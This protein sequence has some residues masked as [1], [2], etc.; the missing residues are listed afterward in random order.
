MTS[1][2]F[3]QTNA[4][5]CLGRDG[6]KG[7]HAHP[8]LSRLLIFFP[9]PSRRGVEG[10]RR[11]RLFVHCGHAKRFETVGG[12]GGHRNQ[13]QVTRFHSSCH[14]RDVRNKRQQSQNFSSVAFI[15]KANAKRRRNV[16]GA[17]KQS[18]TT[19]QL[20]LRPTDTSAQRNCRYRN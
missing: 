8:P 11:W 2:H 4:F 18:R 6:V 20:K 17:A 15:E 10:L 12:F 9:S 16:L 3:V 7:R 19:P 13:C 5:C 14:C 1:F